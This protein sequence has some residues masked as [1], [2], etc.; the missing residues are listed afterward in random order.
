MWVRLLLSRL[1]GVSSRPAGSWSGAGCCGICTP[2]PFI[3]RLLL[4]RTPATVRLSFSLNSEQSTETTRTKHATMSVV[5]TDSRPNTGSGSSSYFETY[6]RKKTKSRAGSDTPFPQSTRTTVHAEQTHSTPTPSSSYPTR[7][8]PR[9]RPQPPRLRPPS[10]DMDPP[11]DPRTPGLRYSGSS[12]ATHHLDT[13]P[14]TPPSTLNINIVAAPIPDV[15]T[16]DALVDGMNG[17]DRDDI[18]YASSLH[19]S[20]HL[21]GTKRTSNAPTRHRPSSA[22][23][24]N[25][26]HCTPS[27]P[28]KPIGQTVPSRIPRPKPKKQD[29]TPNCQVFPTKEINH[30]QPEPD[31]ISPTQKSIR[32]KAIIPTIDDIVKAH[33]VTLTPSTSSKSISALDSRDSID[34]IS[35]SSIDTIAEEVQHTLRQPIPEPVMARGSASSLAAVDN[36]KL[37]STPSYDFLQIPPEANPSEVSQSEAIATYIRSARLTTLIKLPRPLR[38]PLQVSV[39]DL[40][41]TNGRPLLVF[42][43][44][45]AVRYIMG[46]YD[47]MA[48]ILG[49]RIITIDR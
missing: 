15:G 37:D 32:T 23:R 26:P 14:R 3:G 49:L 36:P 40:G 5:S 7:H 42:L 13:P 4:R 9:T 12:S 6:P 17:F 39:S 44:L 22:A 20:E 1:V 24:A 46:L 27:S 29:H 30:H 41:D 16:M 38:A 33:T 18:F 48:E 2:D 43:G 34:L 45:G 28:H 21:A 8:H 25:Q 35:R 11:S 31:S 47:E 19:R 10:P